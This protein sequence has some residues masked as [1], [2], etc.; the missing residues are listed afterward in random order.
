M[1]AIQFLIKAFYRQKTKRIFH[2]LH[3]IALVIF[4]SQQVISLFF[5]DLLSRCP[6]RGKEHF[7][8]YIGWA[9]CAYNLCCIGRKLQADYRRKELLLQR[10]A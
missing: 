4:E 10:A 8:R 1:S 9:I 3:Q 7:Y 6:D 5:Y 2:L